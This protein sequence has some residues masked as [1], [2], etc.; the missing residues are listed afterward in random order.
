[1]ADAT[2]LDCVIPGIST[3]R[4]ERRLDEKH[5]ALDPQGPAANG[6]P[7]QP[8]SG[9]GRKAPRAPRVHNSHRA[10]SLGIGGL[11]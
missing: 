10:N 9:G 4:K 5:A 8:R 1:M 7:F 2:E 6:E 3:T 11:P